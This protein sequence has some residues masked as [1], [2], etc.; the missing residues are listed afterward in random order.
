[1]KKNYLLKM[2]DGE[3]KLNNGMMYS[4]DLVKAMFDIMKKEKLSVVYRKDGDFS[5]I[6]VDDV[7]GETIPEATSLRGCSIYFNADLEDSV[8]S[9]LNSSKSMIFPLVFVGDDDTPEENI[10]EK[11]DDGVVYVK[12]CGNVD[13]THILIQDK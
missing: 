9:A 7:V 3:K 6:E 4:Y 1:M 5:N 2:V 13:L 10:L 11:R 8:E 12:V